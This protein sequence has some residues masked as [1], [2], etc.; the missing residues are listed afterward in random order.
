MKLPA[1]SAGNYTQPC[2]IL[3]HLGLLEGRRTMRQANWRAENWRG[4]PAGNR[5][6]VYAD[7]L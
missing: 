7:F 3:I 4:R 2:N 6:G 1:S 5:S